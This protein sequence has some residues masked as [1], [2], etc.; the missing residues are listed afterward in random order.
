MNEADRK[1][2]TYEEFL[3]YVFKNAYDV[4]KEN[5]RKN[6]IRN[7]KFPYKKYIEALVIE[8]LPNCAKDKLQTL[9][10]LDFIKNEQNVYFLLLIAPQLISLVVFTK[11]G[12]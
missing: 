2:K 5:G 9:C 8:D 12:Y 11:S 1:N 7:T 3:C 10:S 4:R 6:R